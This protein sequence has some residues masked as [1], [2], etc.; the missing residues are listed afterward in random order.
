[1]PSSAT[2]S[3]K[4]TLGDR[5]QHE[6]QKLN[7]ATSDSEGNVELANGQFLHQVE[8]IPAPVHYDFSV[9]EEKIVMAAIVFLQ[10]EGLLEHQ[11]FRSVDEKL[12]PDV[13]LLDYAQL[14][15]VRIKRLKPI[16][17]FIMA[18]KLPDV[19]ETLIPVILKRAGMRL[20]RSR[21]RK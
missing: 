18:L 2:F 11:C 10:R 8:L 16:V 3:A 19:T 21:A 9:T 17:R 5:Q 6:I 7:D 13:K 15:R 14:A 20:P 4:T 1:M 12:L